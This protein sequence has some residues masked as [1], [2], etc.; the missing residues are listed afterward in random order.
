MS[1]EPVLFTI[2]GGVATITLNEPDKLNPLALSSQHRLREILAQIRADRAV[3]ALVLTAT[4]KGFC[5]GADLGTITGMRE[6]GDQSLGASI[7]KVMREVSNALITDLRELP[8]PTV[9]AVNGAA[10]GAGVALA[11]A[12]DIVLAARS[13]YFYLPFIPRLGLVPDLGTTWF[14]PR[15]VGRAR[16]V[17]LTMLGDRLP[18]ER[19]EQWGLIWRCVEDAA[20]PDAVREITQRLVALPAHAALE[21]RRAYDASEANDLAAQLRYEAARQQDLFDRDEFAEG[22]RAF[23]E[24]R[25][26]VFRKH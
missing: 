25:S 8:V 6:S 9:A 18:A 2:E 13:A 12:C 3:R 1:G 15:L 20:L 24:K 23:Q 22:V 17:A 21:T 26:P 5:V 10:A 19:A 14:V 7:A 4:G 16:A 11:L